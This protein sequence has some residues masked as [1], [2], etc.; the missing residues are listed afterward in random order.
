MPNEKPEGDGNGELLPPAQPQVPAAAQQSGRV[1][2]QP[3][4]GSWFDPDDVQ[5]TNINIQRGSPLPRR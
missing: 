1:D 5:V 3:L 4:P 2:T